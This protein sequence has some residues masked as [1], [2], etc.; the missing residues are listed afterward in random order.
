MDSTATASTN[1]FDI[2]SRGMAA[3]NEILGTVDA[4]E[5]ISLVKSDRFDYT[6]WQ[7]CRAEYGRKLILVESLAHSLYSSIP[8]PSYKKGLKNSFE[9]T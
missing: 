5:F 3:L 7:Y 9:N 2:Y 4:E 8:C 6:K 1:K